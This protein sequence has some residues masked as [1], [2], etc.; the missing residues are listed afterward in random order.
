MSRRKKRSRWGM[1]EGKREPL[2]ARVS[3]FCLL[4]N[5]FIWVG[6]RNMDMLIVGLASVLVALV[7]T[8]IGRKAYNRIRRRGGRMAGESMARIGYLGNLWV[9]VLVGFF[10]VYVLTMAILRGEIL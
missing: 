9:M 10:W 2:G 3:A 8:V 6:F 7:G 5:L 1:P 4:L